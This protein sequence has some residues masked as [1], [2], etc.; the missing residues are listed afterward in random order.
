MIGGLA[1]LDAQVSSLNRLGYYS[2]AFMALMKEA[3]G[4]LSNGARNGGGGS[5]AGGGMQP[6]MG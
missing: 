4:T 2:P 1:Q 3:A 6:A 5:N